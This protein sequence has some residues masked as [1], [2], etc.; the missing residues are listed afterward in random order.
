[1]KTII[2]KKQSSDNAT[3]VRAWQH[4]EELV[5]YDE[6]AAL[7]ERT[8]AEIREKTAGL[9]VAYAW[10]GGKDSLALQYVCEQAGIK[11]CVLGIA[12]K[13]EYPA[14]LRWVEDNKPEGLQILSNDS[15]TL[16]WLDR[17]PDMLFPRQSSKAARWFSLIQHRAQAQFFKEHD[18]DM[19]ILG[20]RLQ[21][22][23]HCGEGFIYTDA[24][25]VTRYS[26]IAGWKHEEVLAVIHYFM[27]DNL[28]PIYEWPNGWVVGTA[29]C[30]GRQYCSSVLWGWK[31]VYGID[32]SVVEQ[33]AKVIPSARDFLL[34][35]KY[36]GSKK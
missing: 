12:R 29:C 20:R 32:P 30:A 1:M 27:N 7:V 5:S 24:K 6:A 21:D 36:Y 4:I 17:H 13:L 28:P 35:Q 34:A 3:F 26:P 18:L 31:E 9:R 14:F 2:G 16:E 19:L 23:N 8:V 33:A 22:G 15:L 25:G 11:D 10:S